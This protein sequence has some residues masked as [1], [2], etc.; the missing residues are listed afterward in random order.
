MLYAVVAES[1]EAEAEGELRLRKTN[2]LRR[3]TGAFMRWPRVVRMAR[4]VGGRGGRLGGTERVRVEAD[5]EVGRRRAR[6]GRRRM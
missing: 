2:V 5:M 1:S 4:V 3:V 6:M